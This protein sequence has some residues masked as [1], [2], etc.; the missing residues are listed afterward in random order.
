MNGNGGRDCCASPIAQ[1]QK[2]EA[3]TA[4]WATAGSVVSAVVAS[5]CCWVPL[6]LF[7]FGVSA[8]GV[9]ATFEKVRPFFLSGAAI[10]LGVGFYLTYFR[11]E[12]CAPGST[13]AV[14]NPKLR[15]FNQ[16]MLWAATA[17]VLAFAFFPNYAGF[18]LGGTGRTPETDAARSAAVNLSIRGMTCEACAVHVDQSL[19]G[20]PGVRSVSV[21]YNEGRAR[22]L[23]D[24]AS[25]PSEEA[26]LKAVEKAGYT[27]TV[28]GA[29]G[30]QGE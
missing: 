29:G 12:A 27:A 30:Q 5:A 20:V 10:L 21:F 9:S 2:T 4:L 22:V 7:A 23:I 1:P 15:R 17:L 14:P 24:P 13:C 8:A 3:R 26:L 11:K 25:P 6:L 28:A 18:L 19:K 16:V